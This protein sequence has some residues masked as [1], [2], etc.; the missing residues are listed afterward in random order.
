LCWIISPIKKVS[1]TFSPF[2]VCISGSNRVYST[3]KAK[4]YLGYKPIVPL[5]EGFK[6]TLDYF[7]KE[8]AAGRL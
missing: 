3:E 2:R 1:P 5:R 8:M 6:I 4:K 7:K